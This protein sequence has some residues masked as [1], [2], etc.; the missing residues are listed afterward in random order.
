VGLDIIHASWDGT[1]PTGPYEDHGSDAGFAILNSFGFGAR[2]ADT[3]GIVVIFD[4]PMSIHG[5][6][7]YGALPIHDSVETTDIEMTLGVTIR[8]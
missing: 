2:V 5:D 4:F 1:T 6:V 3:V 8:L 7:N